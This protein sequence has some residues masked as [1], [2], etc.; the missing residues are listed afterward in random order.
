MLAVIPTGNETLEALWRDS[1]RHLFVESYVGNLYLVTRAPIHDLLARIGEEIS[2]AGQEEKEVMPANEFGQRYYSVM[3][4]I[5]AS[6]AGVKRKEW[7]ARGDVEATVVNL[8]QWLYIYV[9]GTALFWS[10]Q[11][12]LSN[13]SPEGSRFVILPVP[14]DGN[15]PGKVGL[16]FQDPM[17]DPITPEENPFELPVYDLRFE[18]VPKLDPFDVI[19]KIFRSRLEIPESKYLGGMVFRDAEGQAKLVLFSA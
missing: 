12:T 4:S 6:L 7:M 5:L 11:N 18:D 17:V 16:I 9:Q 2:A 1:A 3:D 10:V 14:R 13:L 8:P 19:A 15:W